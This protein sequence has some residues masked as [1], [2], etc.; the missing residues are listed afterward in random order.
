MKTARNAVIDL[1]KALDVDS[2]ALTALFSIQVQCKKELGEKTPF[3]CKPSATTDGS[4]SYTIS[5][6]DV[7]RGIFEEK[8]IHYDMNAK[9]Q[10]VAFRIDNQYGL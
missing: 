1:N 10:I 8:G 9:R 5:L 2:E 6:L 4:I 3:K 7:L